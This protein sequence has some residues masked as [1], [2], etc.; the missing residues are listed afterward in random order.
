MKTSRR[1]LTAL[2]ATGSIALALP[3]A[4]ARPM[5]GDDGQFCPR[6]GPMERGGHRFEHG[7]GE[8]GGMLGP[9]HLR[10]LN[11]SDEQEDKVFNLMHGQKPMLRA[12]MRELR[13]A[14]SNLEALVRSPNYDEAKVRALTGKAADTLA[15]VFRLRAHTEHE[16][17]QIL[18]PEQRQAL[19]ERR[20]Q[21]RE[22]GRGSRHF[23]PGMGPGHGPGMAPSQS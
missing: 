17:Y 4:Q 23:S 6:G 2:L 21:R 12:K 15:D 18:T 7:M 8:L 1:I 13:D 22:M 10:G 3:A 16:I 14:R 19:E 20:A 5:M 11:L 9:R